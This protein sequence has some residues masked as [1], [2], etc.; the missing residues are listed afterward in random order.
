VGKLIRAAGTRTMVNVDFFNLFKGSAV[1]AENPSYPAAYRLPTQIMLARFV[2]ISA[3]F[4]FYSR[5]SLVSVISRTPVLS[6]SG[7]SIS[8][9]VP[10]AHQHK[11]AAV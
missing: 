4:D 7:R 6:E 2:K 5:N 1:T 3:Q 9:V 8:A 10:A 11:R